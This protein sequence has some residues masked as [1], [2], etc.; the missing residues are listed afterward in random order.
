MTEDLQTE[1]AKLRAKNAQLLDEKKKAV[2][3]RDR[4]AEQ[5][6][7]VT[8]ERD[9]AQGEIQRITVDQPR[10]DLLEENA[11]P[12]MAEV[13]QRE[14]LHHFNIENVEGRDMLTH[15]DGTPV[16]VAHM[17]KATGSEVQQPVEFSA[18]GL[19]ALF[20]ADLVPGIGRLL[21]GSKASGGGAPGSSG[22]QALPP[23]NQ[24]HEKAANFGF[25]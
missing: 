6:E 25:R 24:R 15:K 17:D 9:H 1:V 3:E 11:A 20:D 19:S 22:G 21:A 5:V 16:T 2:A 8:A 7:A 4:L 23:T 12:G 10:L 14:L 18:A 13:L